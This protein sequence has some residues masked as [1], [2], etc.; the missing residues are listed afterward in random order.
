[1]FKFP[2]FLLYEKRTPNR[3]LKM[4]KTISMIF[5]V[6]AIATVVGV[7]V[8]YFDNRNKQIEKMNKANE[9]ISEVYAE[10]GAKMDAYEELQYLSRFLDKLSIKIDS[11]ETSLYEKQNI[12]KDFNKMNLIIDVFQKST[13]SERLKYFLSGVQQLD[14]D[15]LDYE[16]RGE[17]INLFNFKGYQHLDNF[18]SC[19]SAARQFALEHYDT[20]LLDL[21]DI[22][23]EINRRFD[24]A[25]IEHK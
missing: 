9:I 4:K 3:R 16:F 10:R 19:E 5:I 18:L 20:F 13:S 8:V 25:G 23:D 15:E 12:V 17:L 24:E 22:T 7:R 1:M 21:G 6:L 2:V 11:K 14:L